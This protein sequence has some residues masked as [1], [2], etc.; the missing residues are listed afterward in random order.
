MELS[1]FDEAGSIEEDGSTILGEG[2]DDLE[3]GVI[4]R[5]GEVLGLV[6][7][8]ESRSFGAVDGLGADYGGPIIKLDLSLTGFGEGT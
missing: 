4:G 5:G 1:L 3:T 7:P 8:I 6:L 2:E